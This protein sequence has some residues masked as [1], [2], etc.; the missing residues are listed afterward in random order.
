MTQHR[1]TFFRFIKDMN[2]SEV[3]YV[4]IRGFWQLPDKPDTDIDFLVYHKDWD[5][6]VE[7][8]LRHLSTDKNEPLRNFGF[9]EW[10]DMLYWPLFTPGPADGSIPNGRFRVDSYN[11][12]YFASP[13]GNFSSNWT[14]PQAFNERLFKTKQSVSAMGTFYN[15]PSPENEIVLLVARD[16]LDLKGSWKGKHQNRVSELLE[17]MSDEEAAKA[18]AGVFPNG[19]KIVEAMRRN[20]FGAIF[21]LAMG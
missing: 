3:S 20:D 11:S 18:L 6:Y 7:V 2:E 9:A 19:D 8:A 17:G 10:A 21:K 12:P 15:I 1:D 16:V 13:Y 14:L 4:L 5:K